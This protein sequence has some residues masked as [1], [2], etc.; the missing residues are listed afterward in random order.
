MKILILGCSDIAIRRIIPAIKKISDLKFDIA[1]K[2][3]KKKNYGQGSWFKDYDTALKKTNAS[4]V[5]ISLV[6]ADHF[7]YAKKSLNKNKHVIVDKP[8]TVNFKKTLYLTKL[9]RKKKLLL[10]EALVFHYHRQFALIK[11]IIKTNKDQINKIIMKFCI[12]KPKKSN[13][14]LSKKLGGGCL[15]DMSPYAIS[16]I[17]NF[18]VGNLVY[19]NVIKKKKNNINESFSINTATKK[20]E[21]YGIFSH[22]SEYV[23]SITF[24]S[25]S[26]IMEV[27]RFSA[28]PNN[29][30]LQILFRKKNTTKYII[31]RKDDTFKKYL[32]EV[33]SK[34]KKKNFYYY[35]NPIEHDAKLK[36]KILNI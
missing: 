6:N 24:H 14:K 30:D 28:P 21:F 26:Y 23:N 16:V 10:T 4:I 15:N 8:I 25:N 29:I 3:G 12:P 9:A 32:S 33:V 17:R 11:K 27:N 18:L 7:N 13:F 31:V 20:I 5:Y 22:N 36:Y 34:I 19:K 1:S 35:L 2:S